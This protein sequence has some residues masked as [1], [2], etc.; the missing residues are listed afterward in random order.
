MI[1][2]FPTYK[3]NH[4]CEFCYLHDKHYPEVLDLNILEKRLEEITQ[5]YE[6]EKFNTYGG[7]ITLLDEDYLIRLNSIL[8]RYNVKNYVSSNLYNIEKLNL[9]TN[10]YIS[11]SINEERADYKY[12]IETLKNNKHKFECL[13]VLS[14]ITPS[15]LNKD[16]YT[17]L[18]S[19]NGLGIDW[20]SFIKYYPSI[21]TGDVY[22]IQQNEYEDCL[23]RILDTYLNNQSDFDFK[24]S[25]V[26]SL[27]NCIKRTYPIA[28]NDQII[29]IDPNGNYCS[30]YYD[31]NN[32]EYFKTYANINDYIKDAQE[33]AYRYMR[34]CGTCKYYGT[35]WT[36]HITNEKCDGCK[37]LLAYMEKYLESK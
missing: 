19:Y 7:E 11:S 20:I 12:V 23:I 6:I 17:V 8:N 26:P 16:A 33:E 31:E 13:C 21:N 29:R 14:M 5:R 9:F 25:L 3:C 2:I 30:A 28:T 35:C 15:I 22:H 27:E 37:K 24:L 10:A 18:K 36:E 32:L 4:N 34:K 1:S